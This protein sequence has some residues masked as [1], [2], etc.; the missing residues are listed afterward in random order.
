MGGQGRIVRAP[1]EIDRIEARFVGAAFAPHRHDTYAIGVTLSGVQSFDYRGCARHSLPGQVVV[2]HPDELH[3]GRAGDERAFSYRTAYLSPSLMQ[4]MLGGAALPFV[5]G[6]V[7][8]D[9]RLC[10]AVD[11]LLGDCSRALDPLEA[12]S[13]LADLAHALQ[14]VAGVRKSAKVANAAAVMRAK[15]FI[16]ARLMQTIS[17]TDLERETGHDRWQLSRDFR[18]MLGTSP[19]RYLI[20]R[21]LDRARR[22]MVNGASAAASA[23][24]SGFADQS[25][26]NRAFKGAFGLTPRAWL[27]HARSF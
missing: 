5:A 11:A 9:P 21:R 24:A 2:L 10:A 20:L 16:D 1:G 12:Q 4:T 7:S 3:D 13:A 22:M 14:A 27:R 23:A 8:D 25:H 18:V 26:F 6:A 17:L 19:Y 15:D